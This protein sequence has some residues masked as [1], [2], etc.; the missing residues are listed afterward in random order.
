MTLV[1]IILAISMSYN[2][3][4][5]WFE[6]KRVKTVF[7]VG[8]KITNEEIKAALELSPFKGWTVEQITEHNK[9]AQNYWRN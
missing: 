3:Y 2:V 4:K 8:E 9:A 6:K 7:T 1:Y 5:I